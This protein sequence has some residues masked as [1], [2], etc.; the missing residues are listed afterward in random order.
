MSD[1][2]T[3]VP[4]PFEAARG[5]PQTARLE[6]A[7]R[8]FSLTLTASTADIPALRSVAA[9]DRIVDGERRAF[10]R[11]SELP[12]APAN[13][14]EADPPSTLDASIVRPTLI[15]RER[16]RL[17]GARP[18][19]VGRRLRFGTTSSSPLEFDVWFDEL[20]LTAGSLIRRGDSGASIRGWAVARTRGLDRH[21]RPATAEEGPYDG[22]T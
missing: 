10:E 9:T 5:C 12:A 11:P 19:H 13:R 7:G 8:Q 3:P 4:V 1:A 22:L 17:V 14:F 20:A 15:V 16:E 6:L 18:V 21:E 2:T